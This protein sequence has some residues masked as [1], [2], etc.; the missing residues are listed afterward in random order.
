M[1]DNDMK[2]MLESLSDQE[3]SDFTIHLACEKERR[4]RACGADGSL[5]EDERA[6]IAKPDLIGCVKSIRERTGLGLREA[7]D[8]M[9]R[10]RRAMGLL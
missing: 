2:S 3:L 6:M 7:K 10:A 5:T 9:D 1:T 8:Y 4:L